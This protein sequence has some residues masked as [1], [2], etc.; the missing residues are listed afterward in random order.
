MKT[1]KAIVKVLTPKDREAPSIASH[2][3]EILAELGEDPRREGLLQTPERTEKALR[4]L[5]SGYQTNVDEIVNGALFASKL[6]EMV[7]S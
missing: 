2:M 3:R 4:F 5:T 6:D 1:S 7:M